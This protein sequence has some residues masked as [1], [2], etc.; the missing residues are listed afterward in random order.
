MGCG[1]EEV[2]RDTAEGAETELVCFLKDKM[3]GSQKEI[4]NLQYWNPIVLVHTQ[5]MLISTYDYLR[6][7]FHSAFKN[8]IVCR[9]GLYYVERLSWFDERRPVT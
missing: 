9:I 2:R 3:C 6:P 5:Q 7:R 4:A 1:N 8:A